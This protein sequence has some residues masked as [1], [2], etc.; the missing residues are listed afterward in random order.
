MAGHLGFPTKGCRYH[1]VCT[2]KRRGNCMRVRAAYEKLHG[3]SG[4]NGE[5]RMCQTGK[6]K[7]RGGLNV[8]DRGL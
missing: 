8:S 3:L 5:G 1:Q 7:G 2:K 4:R 6:V